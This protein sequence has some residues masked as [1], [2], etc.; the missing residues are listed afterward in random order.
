VNPSSHPSQEITIISATI[1]FGCI[2]HSQFEVV[3]HHEGSD[4]GG[5]WAKDID[6]PMETTTTIKWRSSSVGKEKV[7]DEHRQPNNSDDISSIA[8]NRSKNN[9]I[10]NNQQKKS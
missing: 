10:I 8:A 2:Q 3:H 6:S 1:S 5:D 4:I 9:I 7:G